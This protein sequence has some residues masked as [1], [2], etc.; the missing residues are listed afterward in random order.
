[1]AIACVAGFVETLRRYQLLEEPQR[2]ELT[3]ELQRQSSDPRELAR[4]LVRRGWLTP[5]QVNQLFL[6]PYLLVERLGE[7]GMGEVFKARHRTLARTVALK[8]IRKE[9]LD[10]PNALPRFQREIQAAAQLSHPNVV[11]AFDADQ[12]EGTYYFAME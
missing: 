2:R 8:V 7:G 5:F 3:V 11:H 9:C 6:G 12:V 10:N 1:M 4:E